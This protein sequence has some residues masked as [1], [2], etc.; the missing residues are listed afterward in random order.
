MA[1]ISEALAE[2]FQEASK[3]PAEEQAVIADFIIAF[4]HSDEGEEAEW[5]ALVTSPQ[6]QRFFD[7]MVQEV[8]RE[9]TQD[10]LLPFPGDK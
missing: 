6:S 8:K 3:L 9:E 5:D 7:K 10:G 1:T 2:A 4:I